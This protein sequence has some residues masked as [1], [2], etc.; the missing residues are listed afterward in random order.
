LDGDCR[1]VAAGGH[2]FCQPGG[3]QGAL[4]AP[5]AV[6]GRGCRTGELRHTV[7]DAEVGACGRDGVTQ[8]DVAHGAG[9]SEVALGPGQYIAGKVL[10][11]GHALGLGVGEPVRDDVKPSVE[12]ILTASA[13]L[14][15]GSSRRLDLTIEGAAQHV[16]EGGEPVT[17]VAQK[18]ADSGVAEVR[19][20]DLNIRAAGAEC[21]LN[22]IEIGW[23]RRAGKPEARHLVKRRIRLGEG[24]DPAGDRHHKSVAAGLSAVGGAAGRGDQLGLGTLDALG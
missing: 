22:L 23:A 12:L 14:H 7:G 10:V 4:D 21:L 5:A 16:F 13:Y 9:G 17:P 8:R 2:G 15:S 20:L 3:E 19:E 24:R 6:S 1:D 11:R 18:R